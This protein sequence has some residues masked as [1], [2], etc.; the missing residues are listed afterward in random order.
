[1]MWEAISWQLNDGY[2]G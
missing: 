2:Q 1:M